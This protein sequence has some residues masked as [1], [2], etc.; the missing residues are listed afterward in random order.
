MLYAI[1]WQKKSRPRFKYY[2]VIH[3]KTNGIFQ[4]WL[5]VLDS[6]QGFKAPLFK[7]FNDFTEATN[8]D[9]GYLGPNYYI[10][11]SLRQNSDQIP[12][13]NLQT[14]TGKIIFCNHCFSMTENFKKLNAQKE[15]LLMENARLIKQIQLLEARLN[16]QTNVSKTD[17]KIL[18]I[19]TLLWYYFVLIKFY[20]LYLKVYA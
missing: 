11:P 4:T 20:L 13:Y 9:R 14:E 3:G 5:E 2:V 19:I 1:T 16:H 17:T 18:L 6:I 7:G 8:H 15:S 12:Q 10:S